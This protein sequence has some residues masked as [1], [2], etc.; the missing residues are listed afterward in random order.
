MFLQ[1][2]VFHRC[3]PVYRLFGILMKVTNYMIAC[4]CC[5]SDFFSSISN[6]F[7]VVWDVQWFPHAHLR[8]FLAALSGR[9]FSHSSVP[10]AAQSCRSEAS[11]ALRR[12][13]CAVCCSRPVALLSPAPLP[14]SCGCGAALPPPSAGPKGCCHVN[15]SSHLHGNQP[16]CS[17]ARRSGLFYPFFQA[18]LFLLLNL[19]KGSQWEDSGCLIEAALHVNLCAVAQ[20][21]AVCVWVSLPGSTTAG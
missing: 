14:D 10:S 16:D 17:T 13:L 3:C 6:T 2:W 21:W 5:S 12:R 15:K 20:L 18:V 4:N 1:S 7:G 8:L 19:L 11:R 9:R